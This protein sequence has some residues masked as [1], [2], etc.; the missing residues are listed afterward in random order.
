MFS[1]DEI[2]MFV[3]EFV[4]ELCLDLVVVVFVERII[5]DDNVNFG[6]EGIIKMFYMIGG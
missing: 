2:L 3:G 4:E 5:F 1:D 6:N